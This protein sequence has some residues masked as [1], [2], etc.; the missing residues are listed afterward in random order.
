MCTRSQLLYLPRCFPPSFFE[1]YT[2]RGIYRTPTGRETFNLRRLLAKTRCTILNIT[3]LEYADDCAA[4]AMQSIKSFQHMKQLLN[5]FNEAYPLLWLQIIVG[6]TK[7]LY[8]PSP[9]TNP[10]NPDFRIKG[11]KL[12]VVHSI[13]P[14]KYFAQKRSR[15]G[16]RRLY[17]MATRLLSRYHASNRVVVAHA[18]V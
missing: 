4:A 6:K 2:G 7:V 10:Q 11:I 9:D 1:G 13:L 5:K 15:L 8:Q 14:T 12:K 18:L 16:K 3:D 17:T